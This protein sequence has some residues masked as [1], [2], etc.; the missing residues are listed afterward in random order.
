M[1]LP[2]SC[3]LNCKEC[4]LLQQIVALKKELEVLKK[5]NVTDPLTQYYNLRYMLNALESEMERTRRTG[6]P[7]SLVM[8][9]I[10][11]FKRI[12]DTYGHEI[13]NDALQWACRTWK[14]HIRK[15]D[16]ACRYGGEEFTLI[17][18][19]T[20]LSGA[21][22]LAERLRQ[23]LET[24]PLVSENH[25][26]ALTASFGLDVYEGEPDIT[27]KAFID[28]ADKHLLKA[29]ET[30]RNRV[31]YEMGKISI[32]PTEVSREERSALFD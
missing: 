11:H 16:I 5:Q 25:T 20:M 30:G 29:K 21:V 32:P 6:L 7:T 4:P 9:D 26:I 12:N 24:S 17:L 18:P 27:A 22:Q 31:C 28:C 8:I 14:N 10:D 13:G 23:K 1:P 3:P 2:Q 15:L 19:G